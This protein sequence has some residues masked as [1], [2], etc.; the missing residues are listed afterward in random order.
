MTTASYTETGTVPGA[1]NSR[2]PNKT[3]QESDRFRPEEPEGDAH[4][5]VVTAFR[6]E[7][8]TI[9]HKTQRAAIGGRSAAFG[10]KGHANNRPAH[11]L[12]L[13]SR[14]LIVQ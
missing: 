9:R 2:L 11:D 5:A 6:E 12:I 13:D 8:P 10:L 14:W 7:T 4:D 1:H 3:D